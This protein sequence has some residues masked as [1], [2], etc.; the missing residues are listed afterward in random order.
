MKLSFTSDHREG[1]KIILC[2][3]RKQMLEH[4]LRGLIAAEHLAFLLTD[5]CLQDTNK[6]LSY[7]R[8]TALQGGS[9]CG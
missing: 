2:L 1:N 8:D 7:L 4:A 9:R 6:Y 5:V 3:R